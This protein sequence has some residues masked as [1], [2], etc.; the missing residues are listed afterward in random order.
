MLDNQSMAAAIRS[1]ITSANLTQKEV[2]DAFGITEQAV[3]GWLRTGKVDK[4]KLPALA[5]LTRVPLSHFGMGA[6]VATVLSTET[7]PGYV[8]FDV[9]EGGAGMGTG[10][11]N[12]DYPEV[13]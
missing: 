10:L 6:S 4:R 2:A 7:R 12:Q 5:E 11:V 3:S 1:A 9:F 13:V 8:R